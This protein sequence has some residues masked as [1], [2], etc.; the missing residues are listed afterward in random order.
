VALLTQE[1]LSAFARNG[2]LHVRNLIDPQTCA[3]LVD[4][5]WTRMPPEWTRDDPESWSGE[6]ADSCHIADLRIR[7]GLLQFQKGDLIGHPVVAR[8][9]SADAL[10]GRLGQALLGAPLA[11]MRLRGLYAIVPLPENTAYSPFKKPHI[12]SHAAQLIA[13]CYLEDVKPGGGGLLVWPGSHRD[14]YPVMGSKLEHVSTPE[15][16]EKFWRWAALEP[17]ELHGERGDIVIIHHRLLHAPSLNR[18]RRIRYGFLCDYQRKDFRALSTQLPGPLWEDWP[19]IAALPSHLV[20]GPSDYTLEPQPDE[21]LAVLETARNQ[22][23]SMDHGQSHPS[24]IRKGDASVLARSRRDGDLWM[25]LSDNPATKADT[26]LFPRG[27]DLTEAGVEILVNGRPLASV[28]K[29]DIIGKLAALSPGDEIEVRGLD[30]PAWLRVLRIRLPF[31]HT[32]ILLQRAL[33]PGV[34]RLT[35]E[36]A[37]APAKAPDPAPKPGLLER[38]RRVLQP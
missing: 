34:T 35:F 33:T 38:M 9:F 3:E 23:L 7:R 1:Q 32:E 16:E 27:S 24:S 36:D 20:E 29:Y 11:A 10:G 19:A 31:I 37:A 13:L 5:T 30:R 8:A 26:E 2:F 14:L 6:M 25:L 17:I 12:E 21:A 28:C 4:H 18:T 15:Y 22:A